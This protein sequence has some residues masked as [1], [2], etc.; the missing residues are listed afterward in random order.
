[1]ATLS[2]SLVG[3]THRTMGCAATLATDERFVLHSIITPQ[4][5]LIGRAQTVTSNPLHQFAQEHHLPTILIEKSVDVS[6]RAAVKNLGKRPDFMLVVDFGYIVPQWLLD[7]PTI[8]PLNIH[9]SALPRWRGSAPGQLVLLAGE[10]H[11][12]VTIIVMNQELDQ[13][14]ILTQE[15]FLVD[16]NWT[17]TEYYHRSF[18]LA[19][20]N[21]ATSL[22]S[23]V[24]GDAQ[25]QP[26][27][28]NSPTPI[29][30]RLNKTDSFV[31]W[32]VIDQAMK[33]RGLKPA[34]PLEIPA[35][36]ADQ[37]VFITLLESL[38][39]HHHAQAIHQA[40]KAFSPWPILWTEIP[41]TKGP[42][43]MQILE[44]ELILQEDATQRLQLNTVK[45]EGLGA[46]SWAAIKNQLVTKNFEGSQS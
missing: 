11:S 29:A 9:P 13:G 38:P 35:A 20:Q 16:P 7:W 17:Q 1:M 43:R 22:L 4:P 32:L 39:V 30:R 26:Q 37:P 41:T 45:I 2:V 15:S 34:Q 6:V 21:L 44:T 31:S 12:A 18:Q 33:Q 36:V 42:K 25:P 3:S 27:P 40:T 19:N 28:T 8:A 23:L 24:N 46:T 14:P 5:Q 10:P